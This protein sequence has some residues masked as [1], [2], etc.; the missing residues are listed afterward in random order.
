MDHDNEDNEDTFE[1]LPG[2]DS[3]EDI[4]NIQEDIQEP[5]DPLP[6]PLTDAELLEAV[7]SA[8]RVGSNRPVTQSKEENWEKKLICS[9][10]GKQPLPVLANVLIVLRL[11]PEWKNAIA[12]DEFTAKITIARDLPW[13]DRTGTDW[14]DQHNRK[15]TEWLQHA[16]ILVNTR[17]TGEYP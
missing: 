15:L 3:W 11:S 10:K 16:R 1:D 9:S 2:H 7:S 17:I 5:I 4:P 6:Y 13:G 14:T 8:G 12:W